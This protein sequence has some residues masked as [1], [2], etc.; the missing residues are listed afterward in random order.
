MKDTKIRPDI[1]EALL[2]ARLTCE[3]EAGTPKGA[4]EAFEALRDRNPRRAASWL[5]SSGTRP[6]DR[7]TT[8]RLAGAYLAVEVMNVPTV[9]PILPLAPAA[10]P[11]DGRLDVVLVAAADRD[12]LL[13]PIT[14]P[15]TAGDLELLRGRSARQVQ[16]QGN[17]CLPSESGT[18]RC[19]HWSYRA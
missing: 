9:G 17:S 11:D 19:G 7:E 18:P 4:V 8:R 10:R 2:L 16:V 6:F 13:E 15:G 1:D 14:N 3:L 12:L 5:A